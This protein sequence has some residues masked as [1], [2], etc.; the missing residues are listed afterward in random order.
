MTQFKIGDTVKLKSGGSLM[1]IAGII[2]CNEKTDNRK[3]LYDS[4]KDIN[5]DESTFY[6]C[7]WFNDNNE[8][9][10]DIFPEG[11]L[12]KSQTDENR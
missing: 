1:T 11:V 7:V 5:P 10:Q 3:M 8:L 9:K 12:T 4:L 2:G 6:I